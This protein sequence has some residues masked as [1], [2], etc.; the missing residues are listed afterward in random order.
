M[1]IRGQIGIYFIYAVSSCIS[2]SQVKLCQIFDW[3]LKISFPV[4]DYVWSVTILLKNRL[5]NWN[6][7]RSVLIPHITTDPPPAWT[8]DTG[9][10][11]SINSCCWCQDTSG[12]MMFLQSSTVQFWC[13]SAQCSLRFCSWLT[14]VKSDVTFYCCSQSSLKFDVLRVLGSL[15]VPI[16]RDDD[17]GKWIIL[18]MKPWVST[19]THKI[20]F[21]LK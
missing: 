5:W 9:H 2:S 17:I 1:L 18:K 14:G 12:Q 6:E 19:N 8:V 11:S 7:A 20:L 15:F 3:R 16:A 4:V 10:D 13:T 21:Y